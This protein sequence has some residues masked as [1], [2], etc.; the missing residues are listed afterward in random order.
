M[1]LSSTLPRLLLLVLS[2]YISATLMAL[3]AVMWGMLAVMA[4][5][6]YS[7]GT[8]LACLHWLA[9]HSF[10][11]MDGFKQGKSITLSG[12]AGDISFTRLLAYLAFVLG[13]LL[14][15]IDLCGRWLLQDRWL[16]T[17]KFKFY[18]VIGVASSLALFLISTFWFHQPD[19]IN[20]SMTPGEFPMM[21]V[22]CLVLCGIAGGLTAGYLAVMHVI[23][24]IV[25]GVLSADRTAPISS[26]R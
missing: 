22:V 16:I 12:H 1:D 24:A 5:G 13:L 3:P 21:V 14:Y 9:D 7:E 25:D 19:G 8:L 23:G 6:F 4:L 26:K 10:G 20:A 18:C 2:R 17:L 11:L 15:I